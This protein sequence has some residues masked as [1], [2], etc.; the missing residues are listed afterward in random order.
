MLLDIL[1]IYL[2]GA[3]SQSVTRAVTQGSPSREDGLDLR[4][5]PPLQ[6]LSSSR[7]SVG[8]GSRHTWAESLPASQTLLV[9]GNKHWLGLERENPQSQCLWDNRGGRGTATQAQTQV[10]GR[11]RELLTQATVPMPST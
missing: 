8:E 10:N 5:P 1:T 11:H 9:R 3:D 7:H 4:V 6:A 2:E